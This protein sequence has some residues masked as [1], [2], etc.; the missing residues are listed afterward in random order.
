MTTCV[1]T[2]GAGFVGSHLCDHLLEKGYSVVC[3]DNLD[4]GHRDA[5]AAYRR[6]L[7]GQQLEDTLPMDALLRAGARVVP[8]FAGNQEAAMGQLMSGEVAA[9]GVNHQVMVD[10]AGRHAFKYRV[11][12]E[13]E[14]YFDLAVM[15]SPRVSVADSEQVRL[16]FINMARD[17]EGLR[18]LQGA[19][20]SLGLPKARGFAVADERDYD[21]YRRFFKQT[22]VPL[23]E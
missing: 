13:S 4:T 16:A 11:L 19:A 8:V 12:S 7:E 9:A 21:N 14:P 20:Q 18:V 23:N 17:P 2:G 5:V 1:V 22:L 10:F 6:R 3:I 15:V